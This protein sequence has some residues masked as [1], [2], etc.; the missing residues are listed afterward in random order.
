MYNADI[1]RHLYVA[2]W[3]AVGKTST[4]FVGR[5]YFNSIFA[6]LLVMRLFSVFSTRLSLFFPILKNRHHHHNN[7]NHNIT[8]VVVWHIVGAQQCS[9]PLSYFSQTLVLVNWTVGV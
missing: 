8:Q 1:I 7:N 9:F 2:L 3:E 4:G 5:V 6:A